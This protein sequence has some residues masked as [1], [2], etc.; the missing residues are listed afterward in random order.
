MEKIENPFTSFK[1]TEI[2]ITSEL[3]TIVSPSMSK[4]YLSSDGRD[5]KSDLFDGSGIPSRT[6]S[7]NRG[8]DQYSITIGSAPM[9][10]QFEAPQV[11]PARATM[12]QQRSSRA[13]MEANTAAWGYTKVA[14]LFFVSLLITWVRLS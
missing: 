14:L 6:L 13:A 3:A 8:Y 2:H 11:T 5:D 12:I 1:T 7:N 9:S 10:P 4:A